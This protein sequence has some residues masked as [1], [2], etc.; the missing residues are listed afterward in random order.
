MSLYF[1]K[2]VPLPIQV[3]L[4]KILRMRP[5]LNLVFL[6]SKFLG[7]TWP[8][9]TTVSFEGGKERTLGTRLKNNKITGHGKLTAAKLSIHWD[10]KQANMAWVQQVIRLFTNWVPSTG[11]VSKKIQII[12][13][14]I[15]YFNKSQQIPWKTL[16]SES[17]VGVSVIR[18]ASFLYVSA[19][20]FV[21][22]AHCW[23]PSE[24]LL[25]DSLSL[26]A[27]ERKFL[28]WDINK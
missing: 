14:S 22:D 3:V 13:Q 1:T 28:L 19:T 15:I 8:F 10:S 24:I 16:L 4:T 12:Y 25:N 17:W 11:N 26:R 7:D 2:Y 23:S 6:I 18:S 5:N 20:D 27:W 21:L 9:P